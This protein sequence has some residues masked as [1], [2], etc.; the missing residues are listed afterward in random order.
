MPKKQVVLIFIKYLKSIIMM[1]SQLNMVAFS[2]ALGVFRG[3]ADKTVIYMHHKGYHISPIMESR[4]LL[5]NRY[6]KHVSIL[7]TLLSG[8]K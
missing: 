1:L 6:V 4:K 7:G 3:S 8:N 2:M 5:A